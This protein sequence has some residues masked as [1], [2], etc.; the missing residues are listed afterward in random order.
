MHLRSYKKRDVSYHTSLHVRKLGFSSA[1]SC[2][3]STKL[4]I[5]VENKIPITYPALKSTY[6][7]IFS[8]GQHV[9]GSPFQKLTHRRE[10]ILFVF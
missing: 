5:H 8:A 9:N 4:L 2:I 3:D 10:I 1:V 6:N 7:S